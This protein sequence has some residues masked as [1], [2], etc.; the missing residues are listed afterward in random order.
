[1][2]R[3]ASSP[4]MSA[5]STQAASTARSMNRSGTAPAEMSREQT[6]SASNRRQHCRRSAQKHLAHHRDPKPSGLLRL[7]FPPLLPAVFSSYPTPPPVCELVSKAYAGRGCPLAG[8]GKKSQ[9]GGA[10]GSARLS[11]HLRSG[12][13]QHAQGPEKLLDLPGVVKGGHAGPQGA[14]LQG[15]RRAVGPG[16]RSGAPPAGR[17]PGGPAPPPAPHSPGPPPGRRAPPPGPWTPAGARKTSTS[18]QSGEPL[19]HPPDEP[20]LPGGRRP[21]P[22]PAAGSA[23][24]P[25]VR[26][27]RRCCG[28]P[29]PA[30]RGESRASPGSG[31]RCRCPPPAGAPPRPRTGAARCPGGP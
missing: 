5:P 29:P 15:A 21:P 20:L 3:T 8:F 10:S 4:P 22:P 19:P 6:S 27:S 16:G 7:S 2:R 25:A 24:P 28:C 30:G 18:R 13:Q 14:G 31:R 17:S 9:Q 1:M 23:A 12:F 11:L 26:R